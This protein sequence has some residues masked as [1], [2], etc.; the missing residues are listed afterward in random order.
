MS[1][2]EEA[3]M[4]KKFEEK[5]EDEENCKSVNSRI[6]LILRNNLRVTIFFLHPTIL[7]KL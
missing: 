1:A 5:D 2:K 6:K 7:Q 4:K 3:D